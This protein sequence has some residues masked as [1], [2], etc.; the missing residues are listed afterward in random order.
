MRYFRFLLMASAGVCLC[1]AE[2]PPAAPAVTP[3][4]LQPA[5]DKYSTEVAKAEALL[6]KAEAELA[7]ARKIAGET[8]LK[9]YK[10]RL[11]EVTKSGDFDKAVAIK[12][13]IEQLEKEP[14]GE[15]SKPGKRARPKELIRFGGNSYALIK[16]PATWH[17][18]KHRCEEMGGHLVCI[19]TAVEEQFIKNLCG[20]LSVWV[21]ASDEET[22]GQWVWCHK[23]TPVRLTLKLDNLAADHHLALFETEWYDGQSGHRYAYVCEW[24]D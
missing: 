5:E 19:E 20:K 3:F 15:P 14:E 6:A 12:A 17:V 21:G 4:V 9:A 10:A 1:S 16:E 8:R 7:K 23:Q 11:V 18:A 13:R 22:E 24:E 2:E